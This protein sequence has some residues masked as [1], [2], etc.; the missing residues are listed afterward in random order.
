MDFPGVSTVN[1]TIH[2]YSA[3][4]LQID[5][6]VALRALTV[7]PE[8]V[9]DV[10]ITC[11]DALET[12][13]T[14]R[15]REQKHA[16]ES[17][18]SVARFWF[19]NVGTFVVCRGETVVVI[20]E[21]D[22]VDRTVLP[23]YVEGMI[24]AMVL[25]QRGF[26]VLHASVMQSHGA[27]FACV[28]PIG[29]GKS[30]IAAAFYSRGYR[31]LTD[32][33]AAIQ[34]VSG[35]PVVS[36]GYPYVK[37]F[38]SI[39]A[40][41]GFEKSNLTSLHGT[42][43]KIA[44]DVSEGFSEGPL[45]LRAVYVLGRDR[46]PGTISRLSTLYATMQLICN[47]VPTRWGQRGG[48]RQLQQ[49]SAIANQVPVFAVN[50]FQELADLSGLIDTLECHQASLPAPGNCAKAQEPFCPG[51]LISCVDGHEGRPFT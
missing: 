46:E 4:G 47:A 1:T 37:L 20:P 15:V 5:S 14:S 30:T 29:A 32:D 17:E 48:P 23:L 18:G 9:S 35:V 40:T 49:C 24:M 50:T 42:R 10:S 25:Y 6:C 34:L 41:L 13:W 2:R 51:E 19:R 3:F 16:L 38:P 33:N 11:I 28:G 27:A 39:A 36:P 22:G 26:T 21:N 12:E 8:G 7:A 31:I 45:P 43:H 44:G